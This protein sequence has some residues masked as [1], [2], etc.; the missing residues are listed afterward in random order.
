MK[1][2]ARELLKKLGSQKSDILGW[3]DIWA[4][5]TKKGNRPFGESFSKS[6]G[7]NSWGSP[8][9]LKVEVPLVLLEGN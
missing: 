4:M 8:V 2:H 9:L 1:R 5:V 6:S 3:R 7:F